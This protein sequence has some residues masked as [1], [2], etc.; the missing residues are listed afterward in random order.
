MSQGSGCAVMNRPVK[1]L[2]SIPALKSIREVSL[3]LHI[4]EC[5]VSTQ[6]LGLLFGEK[7]LLFRSKDKAGDW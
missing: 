1:Q 5:L 4:L 7:L 3:A 6:T 2:Q